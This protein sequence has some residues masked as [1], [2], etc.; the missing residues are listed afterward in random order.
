MSDLPNLLCVCKVLLKK[1][2][3]TFVLMSKCIKL[4]ILN[5]RDKT[6]IWSNQQIEHVLRKRR[7]W[8]IWKTISIT[9]REF[10]LFGYTKFEI[11]IFFWCPI[12]YNIHIEWS[13]P[14][15]MPDFKQTLILCNQSVVITRIIW[16]QMKHE[17]R[18]SNKFNR[19]LCFFATRRNIW[20]L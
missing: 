15:V 1:K 11:D 19:F 18:V 13:S 14:Y 8:S 16:Q 17:G 4:F 7:R 5:G 6:R 12:S 9:K 2:I 20:K 3:A 10:K